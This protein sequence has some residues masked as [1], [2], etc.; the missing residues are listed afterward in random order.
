MK[1]C[2]LRENICNCLLNINYVNAQTSHKFIMYCISHHVL[3]LTYMR[4]YKYLTK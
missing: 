4:V 1:A 3:L 2:T